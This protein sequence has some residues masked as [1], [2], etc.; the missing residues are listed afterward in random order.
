[1]SSKLCKKQKNNSYILY[2]TINNC[3]TGTQVSNMTVSNNIKRDIINW[4]LCLEVFVIAY[5]SNCSF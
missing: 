1:M 4:D 3:N 2:K 5:T